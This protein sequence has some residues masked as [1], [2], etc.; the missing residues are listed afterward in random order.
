[1]LGKRL[2]ISDRK[3]SAILA[4]ARTQ[5]E[6]SGLRNFTL[7]ALASKSGVTRQTVHNLFGT[8]L[9]LLE[10]L[11]D[12]LAFGGG[13]ARMREVM[14]QTDA[15]AMLMSFVEVFT[16]FWAR[17]RLLIRRIHG[18]AAIDPEFGAAVEARNLRRKGA[19]ERVVER[20]DRRI[21]GA[22]SEERM[23]KAATLYALTSFEFFDVLAEGCGRIDGATQ[24]IKKLVQ[25]IFSADS[26]GHA[27]AI[28]SA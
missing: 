25:M 1:V 24:E 8:R 13:M 14:Q 21:P 26:S 27:P 7:D 20:F 15:D 17:D 5:L 6:S 10:A 4:A 3:R 18:L 9:G 11:F 2:E 23:R 19:A 22:P 12:Q 16:G 28:P